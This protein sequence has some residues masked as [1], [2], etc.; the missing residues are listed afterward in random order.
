MARMG[1]RTKLSSCLPH[2]SRLLGRMAGSA[3]SK[4]GI[5]ESGPSCR[6]GPGLIV[7]L[8][9]TFPLLVKPPEKEK[10]L[11]GCLSLLGAQFR[12]S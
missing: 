6:F 3:T 11:A 9:G 8:Q 4:K 5:F 10:Q 12:H 2:L 7:A 1:E